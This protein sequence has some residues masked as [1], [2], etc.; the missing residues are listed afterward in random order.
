MNRSALRLGALLVGLSI[1]RPAE[2]AA[3]PPWERGVL[4]PG[5]QPA[6]GECRVYRPDL[7]PGHQPPPVP[8][9]YAPSGAYGPA[10]YGQ[11]DRGG[12]G[13]VVDGR[14]PGTDIGVRAQWR[15][16]V[17]IGGAY[18][19]APGDSWQW[20]DEDAREA[21]ERQQEW[22]REDVQRQDEWYR[23]DAQRQD[24]WYREEAQRWNEREREAWKRQDE[25]DREAWKRYD[26]S[27]REAQKRDE[28]RY[29]E[30]R[31]RQEERRREGRRGPG[32]G[33]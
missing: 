13:V 1:I 21:W 23:E 8:C 2:G 15:S 18:Q 31:K 4:P 32:G 22:Y 30:A 6:P 28:E 7:P 5:H 17:P 14:I 25:A 33:R 16:G 19:G 29:R 3:Q 27:V 26:E 11:V 12:I 20:I 24:E 9:A 10:G